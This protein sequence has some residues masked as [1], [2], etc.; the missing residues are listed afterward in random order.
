MVERGADV[1]EGEIVRVQY[2]FREEEFERFGRE[3]WFGSFEEGGG[4]G[5]GF[6]GV[7][8]ACVEPE[9]MISVM[10]VQGRREGRLNPMMRVT[11]RGVAVPS[12]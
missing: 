4:G 10:V 9:R 12:A 3:R 8:P 5:V 6:R 11:S 2:E 7:V 1:V